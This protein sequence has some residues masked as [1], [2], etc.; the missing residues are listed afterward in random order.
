MHHLIAIRHR[1]V[2]RV[3]TAFLVRGVDNRPGGRRIRD[4]G[5]PLRQSTEAATNEQ[6]ANK[7]M[8]TEEQQRTLAA[9]IRAEKTPPTV[10]L[11]SPICLR[12]VEGLSTVLSPEN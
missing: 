4:E 11:R 2:D 1:Q 6:S 7:L 10:V 8:L 9:W 12:A 3:S 5:R